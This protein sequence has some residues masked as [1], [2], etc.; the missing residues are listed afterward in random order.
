MAID[1]MSAEPRI[2][3][4]FDVTSEGRAE[5]FVR[6]WCKKSQIE[7]KILFHLVFAVNELVDG[8]INL[9]KTLNIDG[10]I[11]LE[12]IPYSRHLSIRITFPQDIP[13]DPTFNHNDGFLEEFPEMTISPD[14]FWHHVILNWVDKASWFKKGKKITIELTQYA[15]DENRAGEL[16][17]LS[18]RPRLPESLKISY[19]KN[20]VIIARSAEQESVMR[21]SPKSAFILRAAGDNTPMRDIYYA[22]VN[23][24]GMVHPLHF[25]KIVEDLIQKGLLITGDKLIEKKESNAFVTALRKVIK[26]RYSFSNPDKILGIINRKA[27]ALWSSKALYVYVAFIVLSAFIF[28]LNGNKIS[29]A[30]HNFYANGIH[31]SVRNLIIFYIFYNLMIVIHELSHGIMCKRFGGEVH[32]MGIM[33]YFG[34]VCPFVDTT[35]TWMLPGKWQ[36]VWVSFAGPFSTITFACIEGLLFLLFYQTPDLAFVFGALFSLHFLSFFVNLFPWIETDGYYI[37]MDL[38]NLPNLRKNAYAF[39]GNR[40]K[41]LFKR[42]SP[43]AITRREKMIYLTYALSAPVFIIFFLFIPLILRFWSKIKEMP[44]YLSVLLITLL[45]VIFFERL[46]KSAVRWYRKTHLVPMDLKR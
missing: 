2:A 16:Y 30:F 46:I 10:N 22:F 24:F 35:D 20:D 18:I 14:I 4:P 1:A 6:E 40:V 44:A 3:L 36:K 27:G 9:G 34:T 28:I 12:A 38:F 45:V 11:E 13:L 15:R 32:E 39:L 33:V 8:I 21:L 26:L 43:P 5:S 17:F 7:D 37:V 19:G 23:E 41:N 42:T 25:G 29:G 31:F